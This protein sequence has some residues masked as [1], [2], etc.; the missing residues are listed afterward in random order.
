MSYLING[1]LIWICTPKC[2]STS[3]ENALKKSNLKIESYF[4]PSEPGYGKHS[5]IPI[6]QSFNRF[7]KR[8]TVLITRD[9]FSKWL[10]AMNFLWRNL[11][12][13]PI[14]YQPVVKWKDLDNDFIYET[15]DDK[16]IDD[17]HSN[18]MSGVIKCYGKIIKKDPS[19]LELELDKETNFEVRML[20][21]LISNN[22]FTSGQKCTHEFDISELDKFINLIEEKFGERLVIGTYNKSGDLPSK[23]IINDELKQ[24]VWD[25]FE[26]RF[27][28]RNLLI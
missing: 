4:S 7:G 12:R 18:D 23:I 25:K 1:E 8:E 6:T 27:E 26:K 11:E 20:P 9:W 16:F 14:G 17:L 3:I 24:W 13:S 5:H 28:K 15:F 10:S 21:V 19:L 22:N 2:A